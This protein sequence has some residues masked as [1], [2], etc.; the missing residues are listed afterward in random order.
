MHNPE[1]ERVLST[2]GNRTWKTWGPY[3]S[4]RQWGTVRE[5]YSEHGSAWEYFTHDM[6]RSRAYRWGEDGICGLCDNKQFLCFAPAFWNEKDPFLK[7]RLFGLTGNQGNHGE[8]VKEMYYYLDSTPTHS[9]MKMLYKYPHAAFPYQK[10]IDETAKR[11]RLEPEYELMDTGIFAENRYFDIFIEYAKFDQDDMCIKITAV[12]RGPETATLDIIPQLWFRN[13]WSYLPDDPYKPRLSSGVNTIYV[14]HRDL[15]NF[16]FYYE[17]N[18]TPLFT[19]NETNWTAVYNAKPKKGFY[20]DGINDYIVNGNKKAINSADEGTKAGLQYTTLIESGESFSIKLRL[21]KSYNKFPF[22]DFDEI[23]DM[24]KNEADVFYA[25][26][27]S[28][29]DDTDLKNIQRQAFAGML[30]SKQFF[31]YDVDLWLKGD[32]KTYPPRERNWGRN[33]Q[34]RHLNNMDIISM[35]DKWEYPWYAA[36]DLAFHVIAIAVVDPD[37]AKR[38]LLLLL[39]EWYM[40]PN[41]Q[42]PAYEWN[43]S[44]V[45]PPVHAWA[46]IRVFQIER[47]VYGTEDYDFLERVF[48]KLMLNF[49]WWIN[50]KDS[51]GK[52]IFEGGFLGMDNIGVFDRSR[53]LPTGGKLEQADGTSWIAMYSLN[54]L[55]ISLNLAKKNSAYEDT[56]SKFLEHFMFIAGAIANISGSA[57]NLWNEEDEFFYDVLNMHNG[58]F[59]PIKIRSMVGLIPMFAVETIEPDLLEKLPNFKRRMEWFLNYRPQYATLI[60][61]WRD[62]SK[63]VRRRFSIIKGSRLKK[64]LRTM[65]DESEFLSDFGIR[66]LSKYHKEKPYVFKHEEQEYSVAYNPGES[67]SSMFGG[68]SNWRGPIWFPVNYMIIESLNKFYMYYGSDY[69]IE[70]PTG[71]GNLLDLRQIADELRMRMIN[72]FV[73]NSKGFRPIHGS[74]ERIQTDPNFKDYI[75]FYEYMHG[76]TGAGLGASHQTGWTGLV[77]EMIYMHYEYKSEE[78]VV[79]QLLG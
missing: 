67:D 26:V 71:S 76:D 49:T 77:A 3:M 59:I 12:N 28:K 36:W 8:D 60:S 21:S 20:K 16:N 63:G 14:E 30:T 39:R 1:K 19:N 7:E 22:R 68:N 62:P 57:L 64:V 27:Q 11:T 72:L 6:A 4:E 17:G 65:L 74:D 23:F 18:P 35:P 25:E 5:D 50:Q 75:H 24:R 10:I 37:F 58:E 9:Y 15:G 73:K 48:H 43:F 32:P 69:K 46:C 33:N 44:D 41:G 53:P 34:W 2:K 51:D 42:I 55:K 56:A 70:Y 54:M 66:A 45:N 78:G 13:F 40:H 61:A 29:V 79:E 38:Q 52:N 31:Y 47:N